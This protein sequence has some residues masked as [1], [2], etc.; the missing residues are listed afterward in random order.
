MSVT[1]D[2]L[3]ILGKVVDAGLSAGA[4]RV[5]GISFDLKDD[6]GHEAGSG[7][8]A[9][10]AQAKAESIAEAMGVQ[11]GRVRNVS[12]G[13]VNLVR[14]QMIFITANGGTERKKEKRALIAGSSTDR[15]A[16]RNLAS[17]AC[18]LDGSPNQRQ[19]CKAF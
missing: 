10:D 13:G 1:V 18:G 2:D 16:D 7:S 3:K 9:R 5:E 17:R 11:L 12:E 14:P 4:N 6:S 19:R 8:A 15:R